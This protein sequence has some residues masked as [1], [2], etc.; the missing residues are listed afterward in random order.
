MFGGRGGPCLSIAESGFLHGLGLWGLGWL[1]F[2]G[3]IKV[4]GV[5]GE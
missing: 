3:S 2:V 4:H 1:G 5:G